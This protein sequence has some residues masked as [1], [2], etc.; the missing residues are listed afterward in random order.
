MPPRCNITR[1]V[2]LDAFRS[3]EP[4]KPEYIKIIHNIKVRRIIR[5]GTKSLWEQIIKKFK[6]LFQLFKILS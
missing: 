3:L 1:I 5:Q 4:L 6:P 2:S